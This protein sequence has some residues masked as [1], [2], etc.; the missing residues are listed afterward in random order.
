MNDYLTRGAVESIARNDRSLHLQLSKGAIALSILAPNLL[1]V[2]HSPTGEF[3]TR[4]SWAVT[5]DDS[6]WPQVPFQIEETPESIEI[7][8]ERLR[9]V[10]HRKT[11]TLQCFDPNGNPFAA[12]GEP[13]S[14]KTTYNDAVCWKRIEPEEHFY[15]FGE[16]TSLL[17][18]RG[19]RSTNWTVDAFQY[20]SLTDNLYKAIPFYLSLRP[21]LAYGIFLN[22]T[23]ESK[24]DIGAD[25]ANILRLESRDDELDY[26]IIYGPEPATILETYTELTG[27][28]P[29]PPKWALGYHQSRWSYENEDW[30][31]RIAKEMRDRHIPCDVI[32]LD[33]DYMRGYRVFTWSPQRFPKPQKLLG[34]LQQQGFKVVTIIDPGVKYEPEFE[35][36]G[37]YKY[38]NSLPNPIFTEGVA[39]DCFVRDA[40]GNLVAGYVWPDKAV[41][42]DFIDP[43]VRRWWGSK[44]GDLIDLGVRGI[45]N[46]MN[47]PALD[48]RPFGEGGVKI[49]F[50]LNAPQGPPEERA[51]HAEVHNLYG[52]M[53]ARASYEGLE[54]LLPNERFFVL[55]RSGFAGMQ[56]W[57]AGW[58]GDNQSSWEHLE[59]SLPM[60]CNL[61]LSGV[62]FVGSDIGGFFE[63]ATGELVA[64]W[65]Q[66]GAFYPFMR[67]HTMQGTANQEPW[68]FGDRVESICRE[69]IELRYRLLPYIYTLFQRAAT[70]GAPVMAPLLYHYPQDVKTYQLHDQVMLGEW[71][72]AAPVYRPGVEYRAVYLP[73]GV[74]YDWWNGDRYEGPAHILAHAPLERMPIFVRGG[75][76]IPTM[77]AMQYVGERPVEELR[78][79]VW[80]GSGEFTIYEDDGIS[81]DYQTNDLWAKT[82]YR[83]RQ[84]AESMVVEVGE[85]QGNWHPGQRSIIVEVVGVGER[86]FND[87]GSALSLV[88]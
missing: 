48:D 49:P 61:A 15:G 71:L 34:E 12:D 7:S 19:K 25:E 47:E 51:T 66:I 22:T 78:V 83:V 17:E 58:T 65:T 80:P 13:I 73:E 59:M 79:K 8:T 85:R 6:Q 82:T 31:R 50:P 4:R 18:R 41:F 88:F 74:W 28:M 35:P 33:I 56:R 9:A 87:D 60:L 1:R 26:Y 16:R 67:N 69:Y 44:H 45:W 46:D 75:A 37:R 20:Q 55:T 21:G 81:R 14:R 77:P 43:E 62:A 64:R 23:Y 72:M 57:S 39:K 53:M 30:V 32:H 27:R 11:S 5:R 24:F 68:Q 38:E 76:I 36:N 3:K 52:S 42:P 29:L 70:T 54:K 2:R 40:D 86:R 10:V 84:D 63:D